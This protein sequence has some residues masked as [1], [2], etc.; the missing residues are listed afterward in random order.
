M[1]ITR[2]ITRTLLPVSFNFNIR[3]VCTYEVSNWTRL[4]HLQL[5]IK[6]IDT[7]HCRRQVKGSFI[8]D[9]SVDSGGDPHLNTVSMQ[10]VYA[11]VTCEI[12]LFWNN[13]EIISGFYFTCNHFWNYFSRWNYFKII[14]A[15]LNMLE[16][17]HEMQWACE[18][19]SKY[20]AQNYFRRTS[21]NA[22]II[23][24][25]FYLTCKHDITTS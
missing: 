25:K 9:K 1:I 19:I 16:N 12:E 5:H 20:F 2:T 14:S 18:I 21:T 4:C 8:L 17:I 22:E 10:V 11:M 7:A 23:L 13:F 6:P 15:T 3:F 24:K